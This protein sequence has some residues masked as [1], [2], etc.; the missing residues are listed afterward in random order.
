M[1][2]KTPCNARSNTVVPAILIA[3]REGAVRFLGYA[4]EVGESFRPLVPR[5]CVNATYVVASG[6]VLADTGWRAYTLPTSAAHSRAIEATDTLLWQALASVMIPGF[7]I[8]RIVWAAEKAIARPGS[9]L[10]TL[11]GLVSIPLIVKPID[12]G[13]DA[14]LDRTV[15]K[16][17]PASRKKGE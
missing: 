15:R 8:N 13:V 9:K 10:P 17:Y 1:G 6:Y 2:R 16:L 12:H 14:L 5:W 7:T 3:Q 4:N 11:F